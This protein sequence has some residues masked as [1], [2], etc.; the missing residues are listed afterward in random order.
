MQHWGKKASKSTSR[1][2]ITIRVSRVRVL[3]PL[4]NRKKFQMLRKSVILLQRFCSEF[5]PAINGDLFDE[6]SGLLMLVQLDFDRRTRVALALSRACT[7]W[8]YFQFS[9]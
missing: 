1:T 8:M 3:P 9:S 5:A 2:R 6:K 4:P 7:R